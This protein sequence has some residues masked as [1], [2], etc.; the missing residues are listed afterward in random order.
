METEFGNLYTMYR[1]GNGTMSSPA[2]STMLSITIPA[3]LPQFNESGVVDSTEAPGPYMVIAGS[4]TL[5]VLNF[6][7]LQGSFLIEGSSNGVSIY[8]QAS[9]NFGS[10]AGI[11][12]SGD[13]EITSAGL[14]AAISLASNI[15][16]GGF[17]SLEAAATLEVNSTGVNQ[18]VK[19]YTFNYGTGA[20]SS[21]PVDVVIPGAVEVRINS[22]GELKLLGLFE[23]DGSFMLTL[24]TPPSGGEE[25]DVAVSAHLDAFIGLTLD[26]IGS[27]KLIVTSGGSFGFVMAIEVG[28]SFTVADV[29]SISGAVLVEINTFSTS[30]TLAVSDPGGS[31]MFGSSITVSPGAVIQ[32]SA[33]LSVLNTLT[34]SRLRNSIIFDSTSPTSSRSSS[35]PRFR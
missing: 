28:V 25:L 10:L 2:A 33:S 35:G 31:G 23:L 6:F 4:G 18:T 9:L 20:I 7:N 17:A 1:C 22:V 12:A 13:L 34:F 8:V 16:L 3:G 27:A 29:V 5:T 21:T 15:S 24:G 32:L 30:K 11:A 19:E 26:V 14:V